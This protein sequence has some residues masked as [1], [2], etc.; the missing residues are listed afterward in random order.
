MITTGEARYDMAKKFDHKIEEI[1]NEH[2]HLEYFYIFHCMKPIGVLEG[3]PIYGAKGRTYIFPELPPIIRDCYD[4]VGG[5]LG[6]WCYFVR[7][8][9]NHA[10][11]GREVKG[12]GRGTLFEMWVLPLE[13]APGM[14]VTPDQEFV[15]AIAEAARRFPLGC[16]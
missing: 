1:L 2:Q 7:N 9:G 11:E 4:M 10:I 8:R 15:P 5:I 6:T 12:A 16:G 13:P 3:H 14:I